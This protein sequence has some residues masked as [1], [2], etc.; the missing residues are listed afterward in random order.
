MSTGID[1]DKLKDCVEK[2]GF[3]LEHRCYTLLRDYVKRDVHDQ[4][5]SGDGEVDLALHRAGNGPTEIDV[6]FDMQQSLST[7]IVRDNTDNVCTELTGDITVRT[8]LVAECKGHPADGFVLAQK[9][10]GIWNCTERILY[11]RAEEAWSD[12]TLARRNAYMVS[13]GNFFRCKRKGSDKTVE[14][15]DMERVGSHNKFFRGHEQV[16]CNIRAVIDNLEELPNNPVGTQ[17]LRI[18]PLLVTNAP[19]L[20]MRVDDEKAC[21][22]QVPW[23]TYDAR[24]EHFGQAEGKKTDFFDAFHVVTFGALESLVHTLLTAEA[25]LVPPRNKREEIAG[26]DIPIS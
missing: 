16:M 23:V 12:G 17:I 7:Y 5:V 9:L 24:F 2:S 25:S 26:S 10:P 13:A 20:A 6:F 14:S 19:I 18:V 11:R 21:F 3:L 22:E 8:V 15:Y 4:R 1:A